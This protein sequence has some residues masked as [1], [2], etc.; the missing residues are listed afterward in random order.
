M[1]EN[2]EY[3]VKRLGYHDGNER[4]KEK[5]IVKIPLFNSSNTN[6]LMKTMFSFKP[7]REKLPFVSDWVQN[8]DFDPTVD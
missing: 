6:N 8:G 7:F 4:V 5:N 2:V 3:I 1:D